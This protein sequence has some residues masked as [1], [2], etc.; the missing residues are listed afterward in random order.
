VT[1]LLTSFYWDNFIY[2]GMGPQ[3]GA[4]GK[5][6]ITLPMGDKKLPGIAAEDIGRCAYGIFKKGSVH[7]GKTVGIA[8][9]HLTGAQMAAALTRALGHEVRYNSVTP[10][11]YR[12][13]GFPGAEDLGNMFQFKRDFEEYFCGARNPE[14]A[15]ALNPAL[16]T[17][18]QWLARNKSRI[19]IQHGAT[20]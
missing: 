11:V 3:R 18:D 20:A 2:F 12:G 7:T 14:T 13:L 4:D 6:A 19:P 17:F 8:G 16:E 10:Q 15:R 9:E 5:F 1:L